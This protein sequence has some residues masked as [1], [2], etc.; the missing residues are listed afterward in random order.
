MISEEHGYC[1][2]CIQAPCV[3]D[4]VQK[5]HAVGYRPLGRDE[6]IRQGDEWTDGNFVE[7]I[8]CCCWFGDTPR[9]VNDSKTVE[10]TRAFRRKL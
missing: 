7:Y 4:K 9:Y 1:L 3:C 10:F 5:M 2:T 8:E 6:E